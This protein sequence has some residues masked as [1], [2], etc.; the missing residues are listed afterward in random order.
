MTGTR[1]NAEA[2]LKL[3]SLQSPQYL[4]FFVSF[5]LFRPS[6]LPFLYIMLIHSYKRNRM[7]RN[8]HKY[9]HELEHFKIQ[10]EFTVGKGGTS[11]Q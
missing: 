10:K 5:F 4:A 7:F 6:F 2:G 11:S 1:H 9:I 3:A 8:K